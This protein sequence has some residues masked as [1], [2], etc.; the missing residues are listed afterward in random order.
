LY[1]TIGV[2]ASHTAELAPGCSWPEMAP[3]LAPRD[4]PEDAVRVAFGPGRGVLRIVEHNIEKALAF[5]P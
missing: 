3:G 5:V 1:D 2:L 4:G